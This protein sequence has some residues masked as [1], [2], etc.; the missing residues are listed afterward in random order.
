MIDPKVEWILSEWFGPIESEA[1]FPQ[2]KMKVWFNGGD[3][4]DQKIKSLFKNEVEQALQGGF[5][6]WEDQP[7][8]SL[9]LVLL[10]DQFTRNI[11]RGEPAAFSGDDRAL[12][13]TL[14]GID[15]GLDEDL[16]PVYRYFYYM[17]LMHS[18]DLDV[19]KMAVMMGEALIE[20]APEAIQ[21]PI[22]AFKDYAQQH[23]D[24]IE[25]FGRFPHRND[26][27]GRK[28]SPEEVE[29]LK[30]PGSSF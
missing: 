25:K 1:E 29:F 6:T 4:Y 18:E 24:I 26:I 27:L 22:A 16:F 20:V 5:T 12:S 3:F 2:N 11:Y 15:Q 13:I 19:Q 23:L 8:S 30:K 17:P 14:S 28:S 7:E 10:L 9:A 21:K